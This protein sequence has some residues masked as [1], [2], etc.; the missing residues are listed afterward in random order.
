MAR[1][2]AFVKNDENW[3]NLKKVLAI[4]FLGF[5]ALVAARFVY[6]FRIPPE[7]LG[8][9]RRSFVREIGEM[10]SNA[11]YRSSS[12]SNLAQLYKG[13]GSIWDAGIVNLL[14]VFEK[15]AK[16]QSTTGAFDSDKEQAFTLARKHKATVKYEK[17]S[18]L[19]PHRS[20]TVVFGV[21]ADAFDDLLEELSKVGKLGAITVMKVERTQDVRSMFLK[22]QSL[23]KYVEA[24]LKLRKVKGNVDEFIKLEEKILAIQREARSVALQLG[25]FTQEKSF[26]DISFSLSETKRRAKYSLKLRLADAAA[27]SFAR[28]MSVLCA[29]VVIGLIYHSIVVLCRRPKAGAAD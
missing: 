22:K 11:S 17:A 28:Y 19:T 15:T 16:M 14:E 4:L 13:K 5:V 10:S 8:G 26:C 2:E 27:W 6:S 29:T 18:G 7:K 23:E 3:R 21:S 12:M 9:P 20:L 24:L 25:D 1:E